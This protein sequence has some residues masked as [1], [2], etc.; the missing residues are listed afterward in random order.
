[1]CNYFKL[2]LDVFRLLCAI[3]DVKALEE[4]CFNCDVSR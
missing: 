2:N 4:D 1:M 3:V